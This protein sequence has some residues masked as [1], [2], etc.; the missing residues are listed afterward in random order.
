MREEIEHHARRIRIDK[1][2]S[3]KTVLVSAKDYVIS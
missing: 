1:F 3:S 2:I